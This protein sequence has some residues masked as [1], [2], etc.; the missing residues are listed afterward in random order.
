MD[1]V[2]YD[3]GFIK[4]ALEKAQALLAQN[5]QIGAYDEKH[6][7]HFHVI[8]S[9]VVPDGTIIAYIPSPPDMRS[10]LGTRQIYVVNR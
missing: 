2:L 9:D 8:I 5:E 6:F 7:P 3:E 1:E 10:V 4:K